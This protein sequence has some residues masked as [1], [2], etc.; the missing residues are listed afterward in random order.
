M[1][2]NKGVIEVK[3]AY[4]SCTGGSIDDRQNSSTEFVGGTE[5]NDNA[6]LAQMAGNF[7]NLSST[8]FANGISEAEQRN[9]ERR[10]E[11][12]HRGARQGFC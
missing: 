9:N 2:G 4:F 6:V 3:Q 12:G 5:Q 7:G 1:K 10:G 8:A 11:R